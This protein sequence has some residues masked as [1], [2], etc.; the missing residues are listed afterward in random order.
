MCNL[1]LLSKITPR[2]FTLFT[3]RM[4]HPIQCKRLGR[5]PL[6][7][8]VGPLSLVFIDFNIPAF[9]PGQHRV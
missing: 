8:E 2:Y 6:M 7:R 9:A 4:F 3:N 5:Y 1:H